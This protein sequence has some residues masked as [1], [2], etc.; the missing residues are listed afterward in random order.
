M[1][2]RIASAIRAIAEG[3]RE[4]KAQHNFARDIAKLERE[5][6]ADGPDLAKCTDDAHIK[7]VE[8]LLAETDDIVGPHYGVLECTCMSPLQEPT[9]WRD[10]ACPVHSREGEAN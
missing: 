10:P 3:V 6:M 4:A 7:T 2:K 1:W 9:L 5:A 8:D